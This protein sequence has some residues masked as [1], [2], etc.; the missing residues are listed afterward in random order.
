MIKLILTTE[1]Q[2]SYNLIIK[3]KIKFLLIDLKI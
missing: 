1:N 3:R 2:S